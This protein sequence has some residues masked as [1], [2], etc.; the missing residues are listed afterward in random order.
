MARVEVMAAMLL[1]CFP[2]LEERHVRQHCRSDGDR[3]GVCYRCGSPGHRAAECTGRVVCPVCSTAGKEAT[4]RL[5]GEACRRPAANGLPGAGCGALWIGPR[6][7][8]AKKRRDTRKPRREEA[9]PSAPEDLRVLT[10]MQ[11]EEP[12]PPSVGGEWTGADYEEHL[13]RVTGIIRRYASHPVVVARDFNA[14]S[15]AWSSPVTNHRGRLIESWAASSGLHF[16]TKARRSSVQAR[17]RMQRT[18]RTGNVAEATRARRAFRTARKALCVAIVK[19]KRVS[20]QPPFLDNVVEALFPDEGLP[21]LPYE[22]P[23]ADWNEEWEVSGDELTWAARRLGGA[24]KAPGPDGV[25]G[26]AWALVL[27]DVGARLRRLFT[28]CLRTG[29]FPSWW[30]RAGLIL[31]PKVGRPLDA[32][33]AYRPICLL[34]ER[35]RYGITAFS[36]TCSILSATI[37]GRGL[38]SSSTVMDSNA[39]GACGAGSVLGSLLW[40]LA[41]ERVLR[42]ALPPGSTVVWY[43]DYTLVLSGGS[44]WVEATALANVAVK[45]VVRKIRAL[46]LRV[47]P[48]NTEAIFMHAPAEGRPTQAHIMVEDTRVDVGPA[49]KYLGLTFDGTWGFV[50]HFERL[51]PKLDR[52]AGALACLQ[53]NFGGPRTLVRRLFANTVHSMALYGASV[54]A[55]EMKVSRLIR[56]LL[57]SAQRVMA[58]RLTRAYRTVSHTAV[59]VL[60]G[61]LP[62]ELLAREHAKTYTR[63]RAPR[64][65]GTRLS[66]GTIGRI[67][68]RGRR[69]ALLLWQ[70]QHWGFNV[71]GRRT[72]EAIRLC[73]LE[74]VDRGQGEL[75]FH[76]TQV[77]TGHGCFDRSVLIAV[78]GGD[79][80][81]LAVV[82]TMV[83]SKEAWEK[84]LSFCS[85]VM[86]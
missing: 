2:C 57:N 28:G 27:A 29:T 65:E 37:S 67:R 53:P 76:L 77:L 62:A 75:T 59:T 79:L 73:L 49:L 3:S 19:A 12:P 51:S 17:R 25:S 11:M 21:P 9:G 86:G 52:M 66:A 63:L 83:G 34:D 60:A 16:S 84:V 22:G 81:L 31:I 40:D 69:R 70:E 45:Y 36:S 71:P 80:S 32:P 58:N 24:R 30:K 10:E 43:A 68:A 4:H 41:F 50:K 54:W 74:Y 1:Q 47:A 56:V 6:S 7:L 26:R 18:K 82:R 42:S 20:F 23:P 85:S 33:S 61:M 14:K 39:E 8:S 64:K 35:R 78:V 44:D 46:G 5:G 15:G 55:G 72:I 38:W 48:P 13:D